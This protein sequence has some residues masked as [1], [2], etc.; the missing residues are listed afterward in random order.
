MPRNSWAVD[1]LK[2]IS[3]NQDAEGRR[4]RWDRLPAKRGYLISFWSQEYRKISFSEKLK[5]NSEIL[6]K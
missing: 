5:R 2:T 3:G 4:R 6:D 1:L